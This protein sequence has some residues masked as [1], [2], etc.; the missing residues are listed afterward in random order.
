MTFSRF[1]NALI[2]GLAL[3]AGPG[4]AYAQVDAIRGGVTSAATAADLT[5]AQCNGS[6]CLIEII[7]NV[8]AVAIQ[9]A[10]V[11]LLCYLLYAGFLYMTAGGESKD[12]QKAQDMIKNAV[13]GL[14]IV[15]ISFAVSRFVLDQVQAVLTGE[16][17]AA[18]TG[19]AA[20][21]GGGGTPTR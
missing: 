14:V 17:P 10:G 11:I 19:S 3:L 9:F 7:G 15:V 20:P 21:V 6:A 1:T 16:R 13:I 18:T 2:L 8:V 5:T 12:V 4:V